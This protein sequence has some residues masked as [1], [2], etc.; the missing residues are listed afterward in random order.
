MRT[1]K[2]E[3]R[4]RIAVQLPIA[5]LIGALGCGGAATPLSP[6]SSTTATTGYRVSG[7]VTDDAGSRIPG[8][9]VILDH[10]PNLP[11]LNPAT[12]R[13]T[14]R[15]ASDGSYAFVLAPN[16]LQPGYDPFAMIRAYTNTNTQQHF[17][18]AQSLVR[19]GGS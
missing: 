1:E 6:D 15:T 13:L 5:V 4:N 17:A 3:G 19:E 18:N 12:V 10:G 11:D 9:T 14:T 2:L 16:Q 7:V 8:A